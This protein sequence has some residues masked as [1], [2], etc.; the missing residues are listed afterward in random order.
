[1]C[2]LLFIKWVH[3]F[4]LILLLFSFDTTSS[5]HGSLRRDPNPIYVP[6]A[7]SLS[8]E[9]NMCS[10]G[11]PN[12]TNTH[13]MV[14]R[15]K[16][17]VFK[18]KVFTTEVPIEPRTMKE[19]LSKSEWLKVMQEEYKALIRNGTWSLVALPKDRRPIE[20][21]WLFKTKQNSDG[22]INKLKAMLVAKGFFTER[23]VL[24]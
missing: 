24:F 23:K 1:M 9:H 2:F 21:K 10:S 22:S 14:T 3:N 16:L 15:S 19:A 12:P 7:Q 13:P 18:P 20:C 17:G 8:R 6:L 11:L 4:A 5:S